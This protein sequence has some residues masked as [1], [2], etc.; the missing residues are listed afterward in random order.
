MRLLCDIGNSRLKWAIEESGEFIATGACWHQD[1][2]EEG[3]LSKLIPATSLTSVW[4]SCVGSDAIFRSVKAW[5]RTKFSIGVQQAQVARSCCGISN[6]YQDLERLGVDRWVAALGA[7]SAIKK[8]ALIIV[9][10]GTAVTV[11]LLEHNNVY[12]GGAILPGFALMHDSLI[13]GTQGIESS[14]KKAPSVVGKNTSDCVNSGVHFGF[15]GAIDRVIERMLEE[16]PRKASLIVTGG[17]SQRVMQGSRHS[18]HAVENLVLTGLL[19]MANE[20]EL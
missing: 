2:A 10:A 11:D 12:Q 18:M 16:C 13:V 19:A 20:A 17:D 14:V 1:L 4:I 9:D 8:G 5:C 7:R 6:E 3:A 15:I